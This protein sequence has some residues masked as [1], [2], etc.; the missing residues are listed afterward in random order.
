[1]V[2]SPW[3]SNS[4]PASGGSLSL[5][6]NCQFDNCDCLVSAN[7]FSNVNSFNMQL[8]KR[9]SKYNITLSILNNDFEAVETTNIRLYDR[10]E[11]K[12]VNN[13]FHDSLY[14][15]SYLLLRVQLL[16]FKREYNGKYV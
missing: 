15:Y 9:N 11:T 16:K 7:N 4:V 14:Q 8:N 10:C 2:V 5:D 1:M 13:K 6:S 12:V 3:K